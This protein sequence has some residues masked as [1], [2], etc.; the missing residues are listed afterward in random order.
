M[1]YTSAEFLSALN[2]LKL[3]NE[4][5]GSYVQPTVNVEQFMKPFN[6]PEVPKLH[7]W[8]PDLKYP[9]DF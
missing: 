4:M 5:T 1:F 2:Q 7:E 8:L 6:Q 9:T 3:V